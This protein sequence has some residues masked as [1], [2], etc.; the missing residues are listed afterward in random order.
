MRVFLA[1]MIVAFGSVCQAQSPYR[2][3]P[4][5]NAG[6]VETH[7]TIE[8]DTNGM[9]VQFCSY[10]IQSGAD[11]TISDTVYHELRIRGSCDPTWPTQYTAE[12]RHCWFRQDVGERKIYVFDP[13]VQHDVLW[14][15][16]TL[17]VGPYPTTWGHVN[18]WD[19]HVVALD[20]IEL[21]GGWHRS[22]VLATVQDGVV[23]D[24]A[25]CTVIE[26]IGS[27]LGLNPLY[28]LVPPFEWSDAL[29]CH[30]VDG[31][32]IY[33]PG[34][35]ECDLSMEVPDPL[36]PSATLRLVPNPATDQMSVSWPGHTALAWRALA[37]DGR[38]L[39]RG[40]APLE[41]VVM[42]VEQFATGMYM[43]NLQDGLGAQRTAIWI[44]R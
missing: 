19:V 30:S 23:S 38:E 24:S 17:P 42:D 5:A 28:G 27:T 32:G 12:H 43:I 29:D 21:N 22:W 34:V 25:F 4:V 40:S 39:A 44:R 35:S 1:A 41:P 33:P 6:W 15:D 14:F 7:S 36:A 13:E 18:G 3:F 11:T 10:T 37:L 26:G 16:F 2:P 8:F 9:Y 20:S 31:S